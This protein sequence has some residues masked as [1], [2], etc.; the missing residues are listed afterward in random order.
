M[1]PERLWAAL[2][3]AP[4][5]DT[6]RFH[7]GLFRCFRLG[8]L[9]AHNDFAFGLP[10]IEWIWAVLGQRLADVG[11]G[12]DA[13]HRGHEPP[14]TQCP[15]KRRYEATTFGSPLVTNPPA[16]DQTVPVP[17][18]IP[19]PIRYN[20]TRGLHDEHTALRSAIIDIP[21]ASC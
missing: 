16:M 17:S 6:F 2:R 10:G 19:Q 13:D 14:S 15:P 18:F 9:D 5:E 21:G 1:F 4:W 3:F 20:L 8:F 7:A 12:R 11:L